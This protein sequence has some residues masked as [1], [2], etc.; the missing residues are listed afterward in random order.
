MELRVRTKS[1]H[2]L[3]AVIASITTKK[4]NGVSTW[5][6]QTMAIGSARTGWRKTMADR[7]TIIKACKNWLRVNTD[8]SDYFPVAHESIED[9]LKVL[10][11]QTEIVRC[12]DCKWWHHNSTCYNEKVHFGCYR[13][14]DWYCANGEKRYNEW[15]GHRNCGLV[16]YWVF[17]YSRNHLFDFALM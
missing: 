8:K 12:K 11:E 14:K 5:K 6:L 10:E 2:W 17:N 1:C 7:E 9:L 16:R 4:R 3:C 13:K 15:L